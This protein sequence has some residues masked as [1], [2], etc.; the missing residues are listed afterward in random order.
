MSDV[1]QIKMYCPAC[2]AGVRAAEKVFQNQVKCPRC[3]THGF[4]NE[5]PA[6]YRG[7]L[8]PQPDSF[9]KTCSTVKEFCRMSWYLLFPMQ[10][11]KRTRPW[12]E[13]WVKSM[14]F[15]LCGP[16]ILLYIMETRTELSNA[17]WMFS[18]YF[19]ILW[20][21]F[22]RQCTKPGII[23]KRRVIGTW[24]FTSLVSVT[25]VLIFSA[26]ARQVPI[27]SNIFALIESKSLLERMIGFTVSV[28]LVEETAKLLPIWFIIRKGKERVSPRAIAYLGIIS[29]LA[30]GASEAIGYSAGYD[31]MR[32]AR[33]ISSG[34][35]L[36]VQFLRLISLPVLHGLWSGIAAFF[37]GVAAY[38]AKG[39][40]KSVMLAGLLLVSI[41][42]GVYD[43]IAN[44]WYGLLVVFLT[45]ILFVSY[46]RIERDIVKQ[47]KLLEG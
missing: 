17:A 46:I 42:H 13:P 9:Q 30:F 47:V 12:S 26:I 16:F 35:Y 31:H 7:P 32:Q 28:G 1:Q 39:Q 45:V 29:G 11:W 22:I 24:I 33:H 10:N 41:L 38:T 5:Q 34:G 44:E 14:L 15:A 21:V 19:A 4:F 43:S 27:M 18:W 20:A 2:N 23:K 37:L 8:K 3:N 36:I 6:T 25:L 40:R